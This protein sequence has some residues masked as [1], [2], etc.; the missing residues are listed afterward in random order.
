M[1]D[2]V[3]TTLFIGSS[4]A[5]AAVLATALYP[6]QPAGTLAWAARIAIAVVVIVA[7]RVIGGI[8]RDEVLSHIG[9]TDPGKV[10]P[11]WSLAMRV[12]GYVIVPLAA[13]AAAHLPDHGLL[14]GL[15]RGLNSASSVVQP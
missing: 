13:L 1:C 5:V 2:A 6:F 7:V 11:S 12:I 4:S 3:R 15:L 8:E 9:R 10:T 14:S